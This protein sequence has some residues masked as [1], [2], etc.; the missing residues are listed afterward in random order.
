MKRVIVIGAGIVG[1]SVTF[2]LAKA[3]ANVTVID[4]AEPGNGTTSNSFAWVNAN[5]KTPRAYF[6]LNVA[7]MKEHD[8]LEHELGRAPWLHRTGNLVWTGDPVRYDTL[9]QRVERLQSWGYNAN[10]I[11]AAEVNQAYEPHLSFSGPTMRVAWFPDESWLDGPLY[12]R[13]ILDHAVEA[14]ASVRSGQEVTGI[15]T[16]ENE[17]TVTL[18][19]GQTITA[20]A[21]VNTAGPSADRI[22]AMVG[23]TLPLAPTRGLLMRV[24]MPE[25]TLSRIIHSTD[26]NLRPDGENH[27]LVHHDSVDHLIGDRSEIPIDD[28][29]CRELCR[30][31]R[32]IFPEINGNRISETRIGIRPYPVDDVSCVGQVPGIP[33]YYEAVTH[34]GVTMGPLLG[35]LLTEEILDGT[36]DPII[37]P[38][39][40][41]RFS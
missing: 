12:V 7:G 24:E 32:R 31:A 26:V 28:P 16:T 21:V 2:R 8:Q 10:W 9:C 25:G 14:G 35:R 40:A 37:E 15:T 38:F 22:A 27:V 4:R 13:S 39:R 33:G 36:V 34:S 30:R 17:V 41:A 6:D 3:G 20:D 5:Q 19:D 18:S 1:A 23:R 29:N 11:T